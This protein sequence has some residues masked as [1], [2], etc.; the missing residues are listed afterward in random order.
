MSGDPFADLEEG[1]TIRRTDEGPQ[2]VAFALEVVQGPD[3]GQQR[4]VDSVE[5]APVLIGQSPA[6][7]VRLTDREVS[8]RH[9]ELYAEHGR[10]RLRDLGSTNGT[11]VDDVAMIEGWLHGGEHL[12]MGSTAI[13]VTRVVAP[14]ANK[15]AAISAFGRFIGASPE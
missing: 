4:V 2:A 9:C 8:R 5:P 1:A 13:K 12:R 14:H 11:F 7:D 15:P 3:Q 6:C 10:L